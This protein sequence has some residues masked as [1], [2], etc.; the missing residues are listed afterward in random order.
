MNRRAKFDA[1]SYLFSAEKSVAVYVQK[2]KHTKPSTSVFRDGRINSLHFGVGLP[3]S[4]VLGP[5]RFLEYAEDVSRI[6]NKL[7]LLRY[8]RG[9]AMPQLV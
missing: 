1:D 9:C 8:C 7:R 4:S 6:L 5:K 3:Q 2:N